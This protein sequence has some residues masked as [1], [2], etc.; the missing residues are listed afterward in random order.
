MR[1]GSY[2]FTKI[3]E[4]AA[5]DCL[6]T[7]GFVHYSG[8]VPQANNKDLGKAYTAF[9]RQRGQ[10]SRRA[11]RLLMR[12]AGFSETDLYR[13]ISPLDVQASARDV[14]ELVLP[15]FMRVIQPLVNKVVEIQRILLEQPEIEELV[16]DNWTDLNLVRFGCSPKVHPGLAFPTHQDS[17]GVTA[18]ALAPQTVDAWWE[19]WKPFNGTLEDLND[20][21]DALIRVHPTDLMVMTENLIDPHR[22]SLSNGEGERVFSDRGS[23]IHRVSFDPEIGL[24]FG[25]AMFTQIAAEPRP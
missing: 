6:R 5:I 15:D 16:G 1:L 23:A 13:K 3:T 11:A 12:Y 7:N 22:G 8:V 18:L 17:L 25:A 14:G 10:L 9:N 21:P 2:S 4:P 24:R 20:T 19:L